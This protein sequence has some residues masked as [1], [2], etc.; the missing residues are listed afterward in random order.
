MGNCKSQVEDS[1]K[2]VD[3]CNS[4][5]R[6]VLYSDFTC[7][8]CYL[9]FVRLT[10]AMEK[11]PNEKQLIISH[12][13]FQLSDSLPSKGV[14]KYEYLTKLIPPAVLDP[15]IEILCSQFEELGM[16][17]NPRGVMGNSAP[18]H[19][20]QIWAE[21][22]CPPYQA[23]KLKDNLFQI[24]S[25]I[26]KSMS[27]VDAI[28]EAA[29]KAGLTDEVKI[30]SVLKDRKYAANFKRMLKHAEIDLGIQT[31][32]CLLVVGPTGKEQKI[33]GATGIDTVDG[34]TNIIA[35]HI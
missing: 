33:D 12:G 22:H 26:G 19:H 18:A 16:T 28:I 29:A 21:E 17:M 4:R 30:R 2:I 34:F 25:C 20:L 15:L 14:D 1:K 23:L 3:P 27:D 6:L 35:K 8:Y 9:E 7:P 11:L 24:H 10:R 31:I 32:P 13:A 5:K